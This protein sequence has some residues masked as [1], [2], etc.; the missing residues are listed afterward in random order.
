[1]TSGS[2]SHTEALSLVNCFSISGG[3]DIV[4]VSFFPC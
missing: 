1:M 3:A 4:E 2:A